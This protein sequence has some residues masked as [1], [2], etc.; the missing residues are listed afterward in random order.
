M[1]RLNGQSAPAALSTA[2]AWRLEVLLLCAVLCRAAPISFSVRFASCIIG[3]LWHAR[4]LQLFKRSEASTCCRPCF[5]FAPRGEADPD[6][7]TIPF[8]FIKTPDLRGMK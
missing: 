2:W 5:A 1:H 4:L 6:P 7:Q 3:G 8:S